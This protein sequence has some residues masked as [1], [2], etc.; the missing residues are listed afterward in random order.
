M[1]LLLG[2]CLRHGLGVMERANLLLDLWGNLT[3][4]PTS[5]QYLE[6]AAREYALIAT[7]STQY[8]RMVSLVSAA[9]LKYRERDAMDDT[10]RSWYSLKSHHYKPTN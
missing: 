10:F 6:S 9:K 4:R 5:R 8:E 7:D 1:I 2:V 3:L